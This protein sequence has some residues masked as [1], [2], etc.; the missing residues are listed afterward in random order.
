LYYRPLLQIGGNKKIVD[1]IKK[2]LGPFHFEL[3]CTRTRKK[4]E[5]EKERVEKQKQ[6]SSLVMGI[7]EVTKALE[8]G[9]V[10]L[11]LVDRSIQPAALLEHLLLLCATRK[12]PACAITGMNES[13]FPPLLGVHKVSTFAFK[14]TDTPTVFDDLVEFITKIA[15]PLYVPWLH[16]RKEGDT[17]TTANQGTGVA[18]DDSDEQLPHIQDMHQKKKRMEGDSMVVETDTVNLQCAG[19]SAV[20]F[21]DTNNSTL[22]LGG[23]SN[24]AVKKTGMNSHSAANIPGTCDDDVTKVQ[25]NDNS[26]LSSQGNESTQ[27]GVDTTVT[28]PSGKRKRKRRARKSSKTNQNNVGLAYLRPCVKSFDIGKDKRNQGK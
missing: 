4:K 12:V 19:D 8:R 26:T 7:N 16:S 24:S 23:T 6:R 5:H 10:K 22:S 13:T 27:V 21:S 25:A 9:T 2:T 15:E 20:H 1:K 18:D 11:V 28:N 17:P 14:N 3:L